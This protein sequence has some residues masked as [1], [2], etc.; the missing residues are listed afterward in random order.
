[1]APAAIYSCMARDTST[2]VAIGGELA[3]I[4]AT[5]EEIASTFAVMA[6][7]MLAAACGGT[8]EARRLAACPQRQHGLIYSSASAWS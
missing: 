6:A 1:M 7:A 4:G 8:A 5:P 2:G 3:D